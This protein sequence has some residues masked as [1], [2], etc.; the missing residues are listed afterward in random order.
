MMYIY[1]CNSRTPKREKKEH[2]RRCDTLL[3]STERQNM[4]LEKKEKPEKWK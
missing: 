2:Q 1:I 3:T 4:E